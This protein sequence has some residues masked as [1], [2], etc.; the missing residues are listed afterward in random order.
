MVEA[1]E[2]G[3]EESVR[4]RVV[5]CRFSV[6][7]RLCLWGGSYIIMRGDNDAYVSHRTHPYE[8]VAYEVYK[9]ENV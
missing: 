1:E 7:M 2:S 6:L 3:G 9:M 4:A 5:L 8:E